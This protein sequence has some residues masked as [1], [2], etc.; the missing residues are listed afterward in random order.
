MNSLLDFRGM[1]WTM[2]K[3]QN[4]SASRLVRHATNVGLH[5]FLIVRLTGLEDCCEKTKRFLGF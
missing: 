5:E 2:V 3:F 4:I 1:I